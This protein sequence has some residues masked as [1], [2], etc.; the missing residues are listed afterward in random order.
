MIAVMHHFSSVCLK[1]LC[2]ACCCSTSALS[3]PRCTWS[4]QCGIKWGKNLD[5]SHF[6]PKASITRTTFE[7]PGH[8]LWKDKSLQRVNTFINDHMNDWSRLLRQCVVKQRDEWRSSKF[9]MACDFR[10]VLS[11][12]AI[13][14]RLFW[15]FVLILCAISDSSCALRSFLS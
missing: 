15:C 9:L 13:L 14:E 3:D 4:Q 8:L 6:S 5:S 11:F 10:S 2:V 1:Y 12:T 7:L